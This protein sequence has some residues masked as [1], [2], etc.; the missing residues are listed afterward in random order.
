VQAAKDAAGLP[1]SVPWI[2]LGGGW[3]PDQGRYGWWRKD[4]P[5]AS[6]RGGSGG[7]FAPALGDGPWTAVDGAGTA[8]DPVTRATVVAAGAA[9]LGAAGLIPVVPELEPGSLP[10]W[11][12]CLAMLG[13]RSVIVSAPE[14]ATATLA[15]RTRVRL[16]PALG[17]MLALLR[18]MEE[19]RARIPDPAAAPLIAA[20]MHPYRSDSQELPDLRI[21]VPGDPHAVVFARRRVDG[22]VLALGWAADGRTRDLSVIIPG[23][24]PRTLRCSALGRWAEVR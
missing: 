13:A 4:V 23:L 15:D 11:G 14:L 24:G 19:G 20:G 3:Q 1:E 21:P 2:E 10:G 12:R 22:S 6:L 8:N 9:R 18:T 5:D 17:R 16:P 7:W